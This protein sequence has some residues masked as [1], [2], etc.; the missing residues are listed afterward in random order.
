MNQDLNRSRHPVK[1]YE[2]EYTVREEYTIIH[3]PAAKPT[4]AQGKRAQA[5]GAFEIADD[6]DTARRSPERRSSITT[7]S[8]TA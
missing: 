4:I 8:G 3:R 6:G 5:A 1:T 2:V 7:S